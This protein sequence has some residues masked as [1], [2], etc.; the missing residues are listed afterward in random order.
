MKDDELEKA[1]EEAVTS[2]KR[3]IEEDSKGTNETS[4][5]NESRGVTFWPAVALGLFGTV[6]SCV[7]T[8]IA[9]SGS[10]APLYVITFLAIPVTGLILSFKWNMVGGLMLIL[11]SIL[12]TVGIITIPEI[13]KDPFFLFGMTFI[14]VTMTIP[15]LISGILFIW[16]E[17]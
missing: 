5:V 9:I 8:Y 6:F 10:W 7:F 11:G 14:V 1:R 17:Y 15:L 2:F 3:R 16:Q 12:H 4:T 13:T